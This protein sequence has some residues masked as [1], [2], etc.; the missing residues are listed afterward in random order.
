MS[1]ETTRI[2][3]VDDDADLA[4]RLVQVLAD[5]FSADR[6]ATVGEAFERLETVP[7]QVLVTEVEPGGSAENGFLP[8]VCDRF[9]HVDVVVPIVN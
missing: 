7:Y 9:P 1:A 6:V 2:L 5:H 4:V 3:I 8:T